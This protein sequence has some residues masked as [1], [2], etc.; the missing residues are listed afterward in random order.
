M[1]HSAAPPLLVVFG[2]FAA[3]ACGVGW[4]YYSNFSRFIRVV[5]DED[6]I[7]V[8]YIWSSLS[9]SWR[10]RTFYRANMV[11]KNASISDLATDFQVV[12]QLS[13]L[14]VG[15]CYGAQYEVRYRGQLRVANIYSQKQDQAVVVVPMRGGELL[16]LGTPNPRNFLDAVREPT[17]TLHTGLKRYPNERNQPVQ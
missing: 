1:V 16:V 7:R 3:V 12:S 4:F 2:F 15:D 11:L 6:A 13:L 9:P 8:R 5:L 10:D 17:S 14:P